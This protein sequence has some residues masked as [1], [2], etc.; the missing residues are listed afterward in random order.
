MDLKYEMY[1]HSYRK[2]SYDFV[3]AEGNKDRACMKTQPWRGDTK[4][5]VECRALAHH[6]RFLASMPGLRTAR[7]QQQQSQ[8][9]RPAL[10]V[11]KLVLQLT[12]IWKKV[13]SFL[14]IFDAETA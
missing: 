9:V 4:G 1:A 10:L 7:Q 2:S 3:L 11:C 13:S 14:A 12:V 6:D 5:G 8:Q